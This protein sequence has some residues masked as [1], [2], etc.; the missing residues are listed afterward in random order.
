[1]ETTLTAVVDNLLGCDSSLLF[2]NKL[3]VLDT[4]DHVSLLRHLELQGVKGYA[5]DWFKL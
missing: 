5:L 1:M 3:T 2:V 4:V